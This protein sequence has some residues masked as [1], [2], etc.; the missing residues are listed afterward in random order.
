MVMMDTTGGPHVVIIGGFLTEPIV[1][2][3]MRRRLLARGA[4]RVTVAPMHLPDWAVMALVGMGPLLLRGARAIREARRDARQPI[5]VVG[6]STGGIIARLAMSPEPLDGRWAAVAE[7]VGCLVTLGTPHRFGPRSPWRHPL[8]RATQH[9]DAVTPGAWFA[10]ATAYL[11]VCATSSRRSSHAPIRSPVQ[12]LNRALRVF[13]GEA[14]GSAGDG[15]VGNDLAWLEEA[16]H[17]TYPDVVHG[18]AGSPWYGDEAIVDRW[19]PVA[20]EQWRSAL[21]SRPG[22]FARPG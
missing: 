1:Y 18:W 16:T 17:L 19:W 7:D 11:T 14:E 21:R 8:L 5:M 22:L 6:H 3:P 9:L 12:L 10:P 13:V 4:A 2:G 20:L 15:L